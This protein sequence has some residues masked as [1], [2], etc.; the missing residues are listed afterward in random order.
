M[1]VVGMSAELQVQEREEN[2]IT[3]MMYI[4][5]RVPRGRYE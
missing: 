4:L 1:V 3:Y 2:T 5:T